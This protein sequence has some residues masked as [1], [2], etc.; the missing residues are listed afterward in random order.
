MAGY[1][2]TSAY[3]IAYN[4]VAGVCQATMTCA[5]NGIEGSFSAIEAVSPPGT[6]PTL[7]VSTSPNASFATF[8]FTCATSTPFVY[9]SSTPVVTNNPT[10]YCS[11]YPTLT[12]AGENSVMNN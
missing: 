1:G 11:Q 3:T 7:L 12:D 2:L 4:T 10:V 5:T 6:S 9:A 8:T